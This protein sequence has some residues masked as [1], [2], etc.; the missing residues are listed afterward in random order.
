MLC[1]TSSGGTAIT[2]AD[3]NAA[4]KTTATGFDACATGEEDTTNSNWGIDEV[5]VL[6]QK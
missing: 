6:S 3:L 2:E 1:C 4:C 5:K